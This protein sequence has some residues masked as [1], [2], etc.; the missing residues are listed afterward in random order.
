MAFL[1]VVGFALGVGASAAATSAIVV[2]GMVVGAAVGALYSAVTG[3]NILKGVL[4]GA[5]G[6]AVVGAGAAVYS[7]AMA[8]SIGGEALAAGGGIDATGAIV[9]SSQTAGLAAGEAGLAQAGSL[10][11][12]GKLAAAAPATGGG[13]FTGGGT[14]GS[15]MQGVAAMG[16]M[17]QAFLSGSQQLDPDALLA[18]KEKDRQLQ[19]EL[20][21]LRN[22]GAAGSTSYAET[23]AR[24]ASAEKLANADRVESARQFDK[25]LEESVYKDRT[26]R[27]DEKEGR[28]R[29][30]RGLLEASDYV[31]GNNQT[32]SIAETSNQ[33]R[34]LPNPIWYGGK[35]QQQEAIT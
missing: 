27:E 30:E 14:L 25:K 19:L 33:R 23:M 13:I 3:G 6:G 10:A 15:T 20:Q 5:I 28:E 24:I 31:R 2:G 29:F 35:S 12:A 18:E 8:T 16:S 17:G 11:A 9:T 32:A 26:D 21:K 7:G 22:D 4:Y 34:A 1:G